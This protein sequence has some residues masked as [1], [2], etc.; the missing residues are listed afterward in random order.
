MKDYSDIGLNNKF[1]AINGLAAR[2]RE[3]TSSIGFDDQIEAVRGIK[4][5]KGVF[6]QTLDIGFGATNT[7]VRLDGQNNR[8]IVNDGTTNRIVIGSV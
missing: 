6:R 1:Q 4:I 8:I 3:Y 5:A 2:E 7:F